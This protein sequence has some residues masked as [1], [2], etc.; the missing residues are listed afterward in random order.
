LNARG[1]LLEPLKPSRTV[2]S[3]I[4]TRECCPWFVIAAG[5]LHG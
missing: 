3:V 1:Q 2:I 4:E 5:R